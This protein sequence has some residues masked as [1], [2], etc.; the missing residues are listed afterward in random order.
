LF[1]LIESCRPKTNKEKK[2]ELKLEFYVPHQAILSI[3]TSLTTLAY[4]TKHM[5][6]K[7]KKNSS[8]NTGPKSD[9][10]LS[11]SF[12]CIENASVPKQQSKKTTKG[13][14]GEHT[15]LSQRCSGTVLGTL[16]VS[17]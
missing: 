11:S 9:P 3:K 14:K 2:L 1:F 10:N 16:E 4:T 13:G 6:K 8:S 12:P 5:E 7:T 17:N 15:W